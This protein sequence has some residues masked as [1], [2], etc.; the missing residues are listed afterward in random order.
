ML[1]SHAKPKNNHNPPS[2]GV[3]SL[4]LTSTFTISGETFKI[5][6]LREENCTTSWNPRK[7][8]ASFAHG[9][10]WCCVSMLAENKWLNIQRKFNV[11]KLNTKC[12]SAQQMLND[13]L[14][15]FYVWYGNGLVRNILCT[16]SFYST[17]IIK[18]FKGET[19]LSL[20]APQQQCGVVFQ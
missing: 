14:N 19:K 15:P 2:I 13:E 8:V 11:R 12:S 18:M 16:W 9:H 4:H 7:N 5:Y 20:K 1:A 17:I 3:K 10:R 6:D